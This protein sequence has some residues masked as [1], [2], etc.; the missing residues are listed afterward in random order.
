MS[1]KVG[2]AYVS[3]RKRALAVPF[4]LNINKNKDEVVVF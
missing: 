3:W 2:Q 4:E 1:F